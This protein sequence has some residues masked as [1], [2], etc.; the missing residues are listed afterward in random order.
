MISGVQRGEGDYYPL[1]IFLH[2]Q[3]LLPPSHFL[4]IFHIKANFQFKNSKNPYSC[5]FTSLNRILVNFFFTKC[6][7][8]THIYV[9]IVSIDYESCTRLPGHSVYKFRFDTVHCL[10]FCQK[11]ER[12]KKLRG[13]R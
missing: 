7:K 2:S 1:C 4:S 3:G 9:Y 11:K 13:S 6:K 5:I 10:S 12:K 8:K